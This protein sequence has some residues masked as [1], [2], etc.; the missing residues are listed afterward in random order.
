M[1]FPGTTKLAAAVVVALTLLPVV[2][3]AAPATERPAPPRPGL[4]G[5]SAMARQALAAV[6]SAFQD[7]DVSSRQ[8]AETLSR[9]GRDATMRMLELNRRLDELPASDRDTAAAYLARPTDGA[10]D[11]D[12][13]GYQSGANPVSDCEVAPTPGSNVCVTWARSTSDAPRPADADGDGVP[14]QVEL[15]RNIVNSVWDRVVTRGGFR[16]PKPDGGRARQQGPNGKLD[17]YL[18]DLGRHGLYGY[19]NV[20]THTVR[21][22]RDRPGFCVLDDDYSSDDFPMNT[23]RQNLKVTVAHEFFHVVQFAYDFLE[24]PWFMEGTAAWIEDELYDNINDNLQFLHRYSPMTNPATSLD[25]FGQ[26]FSYGSWVWWRFLTERFPAEEGT[27]LPVIM[28]STWALAHHD[29]PQNHGTYSLRA[30]ARAIAARDQKFTRVFA[31]FGEAI[32]H[33]GSNGHF[34]EGAAYPSARLVD[35]YNLSGSRRSHPR[36]TASMPHLTNWTVAFR[37]RD[38][39]RARAWRLRVAV[40]GPDRARGPFA[41]VT[42]YRSDG[43][44]TTRVAKLG[45]N[46]AGKVVAPFSTRVVKR[47]ELTITNA[48]RRF[49]CNEGTLF[50]CMGRSL[51]DNLKTEFKATAFRRRT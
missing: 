12:N 50:S 28:R 13:T 10:S 19:C 37:P 17:V 21:N 36:Q 3:T 6:R 32:R 33:P 23:P 7:A 48:G 38:G 45:A 18:T 1:C 35:S 2:A 47:V 39:L 22:G 8:K 43:S 14:N 5:K 4:S 20:D 27:G 42:V 34:E 26:G 44:I 9:H 29:D 15:T 30:T 49:N 46:G 40:D 41:Q 16:A 11:P 24:D 25:H 51:D 31:D